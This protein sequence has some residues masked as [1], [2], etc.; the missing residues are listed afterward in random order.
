MVLTGFDH[1]CRH[2]I[3]CQVQRDCD[4]HDERGKECQRST[5]FVTVPRG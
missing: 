3:G 2:L 1:G 5:R 4:D